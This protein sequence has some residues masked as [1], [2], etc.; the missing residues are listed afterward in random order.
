MRIAHSSHELINVNV[1]AMLTVVEVD[2]R[3]PEFRPTEKD[4]RFL[5]DGR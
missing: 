5:L 3:R 2:S 1:V 4:T